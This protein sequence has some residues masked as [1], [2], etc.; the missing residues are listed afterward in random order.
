VKIATS[1]QFQFMHF[2]HTSLWL[3]YFG[4]LI[5]G[6][7]EPL[8][9]L[10]GNSLQKV[11]QLFPGLSFS[12]TDAKL[13]THQSYAAPVLVPYRTDHVVN[14]KPT[15]TD[16]RLGTGSGPGLIVLSAQVLSRFILPY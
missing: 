2:L 14:A 1:S 15:E 10:R 9:L 4:N 16:L 6:L 12:L 3:A 5:P 7:M 11:L 13:A 8:P